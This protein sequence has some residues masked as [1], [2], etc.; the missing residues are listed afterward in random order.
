MKPPPGGETRDLFS[1]TTKERQ[2]KW[3]TLQISAPCSTPWTA[4]MLYGVLDR[5]AESAA[6]W[7]ATQGLT[8][9]QGGTAMAP[10][11][12]ATL[13]PAPASR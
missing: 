10:S 2:T 13:A 8:R 9:A 4:D 1:M 3:A 6:V 11:T 7:K 5:M 12:R